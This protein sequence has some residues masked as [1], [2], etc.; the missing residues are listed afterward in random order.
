MKTHYICDLQDGQGV[1]SLFLVREKEIRT[2]SR[3]GK[4]WLELDLVDRT[5]R[6]SAKMWDNFAVIA[7]TFE[8]D[9]VVQVR[10][11]VKLFNGQ[12]ELTLEQIIPAVERDYDLSDFLAHTKYDVEKLYADLRAAVAAMKNP[13]LKR[14]LVSIV[15]DPAIASKLK[16]AP[17][18]MTMHHAF[19][20]GLLEHIVSLIGLGRTIAEH[21]RELDADLLL[22]GIILHDIGKIDE[23]CYGR[24]I[25]YTTQGRLLGHISIG[26]AMVRERIRAIPDFP[27]PLAVLVEHLILSHH[28][29][30]EFGSPS[31][32]Q[33]REA[34]AL[35]FLDDMDSKMG[36]VRATLESPEGN[37]DWTARN[38]SLRRSLLRADKFYPNGDPSA[39]S[40]KNIPLESAEPGQEPQASAMSANQTTNSPQTSFGGFVSPATLN[41]KDNERA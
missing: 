12:K 10:G 17:A 33:T 3:S 34:V 14:L 9:D 22:T 41:K 39:C 36:A 4:S 27:A 1:T 13:W 31:L 2:S 5:G 6:I 16:R 26:A 38:P 30:Y 7:V 25:E 29:S 15:D 23:L 21:Y 18:A 37:D 28:G 24:G 35:H 11:R 20:G 40:D 8:R 32:P 19:V